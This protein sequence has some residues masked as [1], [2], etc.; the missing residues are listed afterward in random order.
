[1]SDGKKAPRWLRRLFPVIPRGEMAGE[2]FDRGMAEEMEGG[3]PGLESPLVRH[4]NAELRQLGSDP[5]FDAL[6]ELD[7]ESDYDPSDHEEP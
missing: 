1:M 7:D 4:V 3:F 5:F 6:D 2:D